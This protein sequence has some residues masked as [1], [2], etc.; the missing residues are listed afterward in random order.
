M[1]LLAPG[2]LKV[3][4]IPHLAALSAPRKFIIAG[5]VS[6]RGKKLA[7]NELKNAYAYTSGMYKLL[8]AE[9]KLIIEAEMK[10]EEI[11]KML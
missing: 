1:G 4:D 8:G 2:I 7:E 10:A 9:S 11:A 6:P 3:G 5:G